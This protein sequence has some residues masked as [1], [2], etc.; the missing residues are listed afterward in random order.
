MEAGTEA[1]S[2]G[3]VVLCSGGI[4]S[5]TLLWWACRN[6]R[7]VYALGIIY[8]QKHVKELDAA[9]N[10][11][12]Q[13]GVQYRGINLSNLAVV[14]DSALT[15]P[16]IEIPSGEYTNETL[17]QTVVPGRNLMF[18]TVAAGFAVSKGVYKI[19]IA[20]HAGDHPVYPDCSE[21]FM[22]DAQKTLRHYDYRLTIARPFIGYSKTELVT[23]GI[24]V[25]APYELTWSC[26]KGGDRP[27]LECST[28]QER[29]KA[30][31][32]NNVPDPALT[33]MEWK[34]AQDIVGTG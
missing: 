25:G 29:T 1:S 32:A 4:D 14:W 19:G 12:M 20:A 9:I 13:A 30:F 7:P 18:L 10:V 8:G 21:C 26:Y 11:A 15:T 16:G 2:N 28:C 23:Y 22:F 34:R 3:I 31:V 33:T 24:Q 6:Y 27:C 17:A 5:T